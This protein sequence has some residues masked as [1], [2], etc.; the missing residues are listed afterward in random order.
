MRVVDRIFNRIQAVATLTIA[1]LT[2]WAILFTPLP[3]ALITQLRAEISEAKS[4]VEDLRR[5]K[6]RLQDEKE[7]TEMRVIELKLQKAKLSD[8]Q[9]DL[10]K[11]LEE[12]EMEQ[13]R[14]RE[15]INALKNTRNKLIGI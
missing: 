3:E 12:Q 9:R 5:E 11:V 6:S 15:E 14:M 8:E 13:V 10:A 2:A 4:K 7:R 1:L